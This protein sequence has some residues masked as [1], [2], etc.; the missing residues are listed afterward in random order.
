MIASAWRSVR[1]AP[2]AS[3][4]KIAAKARCD[5]NSTVGLPCLSQ[6]GATLRLG[7][8]YDNKSREAAIRP[9]GSTKKRAGD[10]NTRPMKAGGP[11]RDR[12]SASEL[13]LDLAA[14]NPRIALDLGPA[15]R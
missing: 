14:D 13:E 11:E 2:R 15:E 8:A 12:R 10:A 9:A 5:A 3:P 4:R 1:A 7:P 6:T